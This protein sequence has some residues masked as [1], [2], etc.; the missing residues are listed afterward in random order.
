MPPSLLHGLDLLG[1]KHAF[2]GLAVLLN[3]LLA[4]LVALYDFLP[5]KV[6]SSPNY[7]KH[8]NML[9]NYEYQTLK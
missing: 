4:G 9:E 2:L 3:D 6:A 7:S 5:P 1:Q 8:S